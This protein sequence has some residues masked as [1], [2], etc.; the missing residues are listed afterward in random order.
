MADR[1]GA[2]LVRIG[3]MK[4]EQVCAVLRHRNRATAGGSGILP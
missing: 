4:P 1:I 3:A 2:F